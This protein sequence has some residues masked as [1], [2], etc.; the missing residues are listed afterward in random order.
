MH[1][2]VVYRQH[3]RLHFYSVL[4]IRL[5][6]QDAIFI[7]PSTFR[8]RHNVFHACGFLFPTCS[9]VGFGLVPDCLDVTKVIS[10]IIKFQ[11]T[12]MLANTAIIVKTS[13]CVL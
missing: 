13:G 3:Q 11:L 1:P 9:A 10:V 4:T 8:A 12:E 2:T 5:I 6:Y 7:D